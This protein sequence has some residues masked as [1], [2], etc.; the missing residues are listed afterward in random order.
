MKFKETETTGFT[1]NALDYI[2]NLIG[3][4]WGW[5]GIILNDEERWGSK[6]HTIRDSVVMLKMAL[7]YKDDEMCKGI[8]RD[9][10]KY[11]KKE[12]HGLNTPLAKQWYDKIKAHERT[13]V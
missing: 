7:L 9:L 12:A 8:V 2:N 3:A 5:I 4:E 1:N 6:Y 10:V 13:K 11:L